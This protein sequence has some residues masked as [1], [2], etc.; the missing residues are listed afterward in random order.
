MALFDERGAPLRD[1]LAVFLEP[2]DSDAAREW[3]WSRWVPT[4]LPSVLTVDGV[5]R[6]AGVPPGKRWRVGAFL[7]PGSAIVRKGCDGPAQAGE[8]RRIG[9]SAREESV[10]LR[11]RLQ[12]EEGDPACGAVG[13][14]RGKGGAH[15]PFRA[16][17]DGLVIVRAPRAW[18][19]ANDQIQVLEEY[20][21]ARVGMA[22]RIATAPL[23]EDG[24]EH[25]WIWSEQTANLLAQGR[26]VDDSGEGVP[27]AEVF[28]ITG[29]GKADARGYFRFEGEGDADELIWVASD[30]FLGSETPFTKGARGLEV[31]TVLGARIAGVLAAPQRSQQPAVTYLRSMSGEP[32]FVT[33]EWWSGEGEFE[34]GP[35]PVDA[36]EIRFDFEEDGAVVLHR[37]PLVAGEVLRLADSLRPIR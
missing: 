31:R 2:A 26:V 21:P 30:W 10:L 16:D 20:D 24:S 9:L 15:V 25:R 36:V 5:A 35:V 6:L 34:V 19:A 32:E 3:N 27:F 18:L 12:T 33:D 37:L 4:N 28:A 7:L 1:P 11:A 17:G 13:K 14:L 8:T 22:A 23:L 29:G